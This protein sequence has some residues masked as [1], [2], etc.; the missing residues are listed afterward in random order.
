MSV[1]QVDF[2]G[3]QFRFVRGAQHPNTT[4]RTACCV[5]LTT[6]HLQLL[7]RRL[8]IDPPPS[9]FLSIQWVCVGDAEFDA[10]VLRLRIAPTLVVELT[11]NDSKTLHHVLAAVEDVRSQLRRT[12]TLA[13]ATTPLA[14]VPQMIEEY[15]QSLTPCASLA[16]IRRAT[17]V[18]VLE[19]ASP[20]GNPT[21][22]S[23]HDHPTE[24]E[25]FLRYRAAELYLYPRSF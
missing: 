13:A 15:R 9:P 1:D 12:I 16:P 18:P 22:R 8:L 6:T 10:D 17:L 14:E 3:L 25:R 24:Y 11:A 23:G 5:A 4:S 21:E 20:G 7:P 19:V 2:E